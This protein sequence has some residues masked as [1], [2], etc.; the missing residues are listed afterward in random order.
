MQLVPPPYWTSYF[1]LIEFHSASTKIHKLSPLSS[2][3]YLPAH[4]SSR[5]TA[6]PFLKKVFL[7]SFLLAIFTS[8][9]LLSVYRFLNCMYILILLPFIFT[10][11]ID[12]SRTI[13][14]IPDQ[15]LNN[16]NFCTFLEISWIIFLFALALSILFLIVDLPEQL[17][18]IDKTK[19]KY[20]SQTNSV[21]KSLLKSSFSN[22]WLYVYS[23][24]Y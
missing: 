18:F 11:E 5:L 12:R 2:S 7:K 9:F 6:L 19:T 24:F 14:L 20:Y 13:I 15:I 1:P 16:E 21:K 23:C 17:F 8:T 22:G 10:I 4:L 3:K